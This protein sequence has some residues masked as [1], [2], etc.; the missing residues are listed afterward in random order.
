M[1]ADA[2]TLQWI[3]GYAVELV[4]GWFGPILPV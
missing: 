1:H 3:M 2:G 4:L